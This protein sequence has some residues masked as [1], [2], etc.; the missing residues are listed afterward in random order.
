MVAAFA[1][2]YKSQGIS[3]VPPIIGVCAALSIY[4][5]P[6]I[7]HPETVSRWQKIKEGSIVAFVRIRG[8]FKR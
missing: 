8:W 1:D 4:A 3:N 2:Y 6:R 5:A 7:T